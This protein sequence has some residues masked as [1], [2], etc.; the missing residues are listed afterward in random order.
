M[1]GIMHCIVYI[2]IILCSFST[3]AFAS[4]LAGVID[5]SQVHETIKQN[6]VEAPFYPTGPCYRF[7]DSI[8]R[9]P[10][11]LLYR[12][13][14][15]TRTR[16][17]VSKVEPMLQG[18]NLPATFQINS[19]NQS[20]KAANKGKLFQLKGE[21]TGVVINGK[22]FE[23]FQ[24][25]YLPD[26]K[27]P[28]AIS[29]PKSEPVGRVI[30]LHGLGYSISNV[31]S[32]IRTAT[33]L[34]KI[35]KGG[36]KDPFATWFSKQYPQLRIPLEIVIMDVPPMGWA[37]SL[38]KFPRGIDL[39]NYFQ[40]VSYELNANNPLPTFYISR[41][42]TA[43]TS[44][45]AGQRE[46]GVILTGG[47]YPHPSV[48]GSNFREIRRLETEENE[49][50][51]WDIIM[52]ILDRYTAWTFEA[53]LMEAAKSDVPILSLIGAN[54]AET[55]IAAQKLWNNLLLSNPNISRAQH[56]I[57]SARHQVF[58]RAV[59]SVPNNFTANDSDVQ[60]FKLLLEFLKANIK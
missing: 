46:A 21:E 3:G 20:N 37:P 26:V 17:V 29:S 57:P 36:D 34:N 45:I 50:P 14:N 10:T 1:Q 38:D 5:W 44:M 25:S 4:E 8:G 32:V 40:R 12:K 58:N 51:N 59:S 2:L 41:S 19:K 23:D 9:F 47:T 54:D 7:F 24:L 52:G 11:K 28:I 35:A 6:R 33:I 55:P 15:L 30:L 56:I 27:V 48:L 31:F 42:A 49:R 39:A 18:K 60:A 43:A 13:L 53:Q 16:K 22:L